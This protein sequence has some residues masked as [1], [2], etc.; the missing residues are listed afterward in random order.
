MA[1]SI[2]VDILETERI[3]SS[4]ARFGDRFIQRILGDKEIEVYLE[5]Q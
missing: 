4:V 5:L 1:N 2:G 3:R